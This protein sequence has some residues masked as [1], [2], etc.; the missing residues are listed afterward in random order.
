MS[1][2]ALNQLASRVS[3]GALL[4]V[5]AYAVYTVAHFGR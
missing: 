3:I 5:I 1:Y 4:A 2:N